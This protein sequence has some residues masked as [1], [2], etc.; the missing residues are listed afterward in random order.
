MRGLFAAA[1][2][3][4]TL[5]GQLRVSEGAAHVFDVTW[6]GASS[7]WTV[8][9]VSAP[10]L[11]LATGATVTFHVR[12]QAPPRFFVAGDDDCNETS[13]LQPTD[14]VSASNLCANCDIIFT[15][16]AE[17]A[18]STV[19]YCSDDHTDAGNN[20]SLLRLLFFFYFILFFIFQN[21]T[22]GG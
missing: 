8:D 14:G 15:P 9:G 16:L 7:R 13:A 21:F 3:A 20:I 17:D 22:D 1:V 10:A 18:D 11:R 4:A 2:I 6:D 5:L 12:S 19:F